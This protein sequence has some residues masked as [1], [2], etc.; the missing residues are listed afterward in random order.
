MLKH[1][2]NGVNI[3]QR[4]SQDGETALHIAARHN[5]PQVVRAFFESIPCHCDAVTKNKNNMT[6][7]H[8]A[9]N[10]NF[11]K[12]IMEVS[13]RLSRETLD[14]LDVLDDF[15]SSPLYIACSKGYLDVVKLLGEF[16]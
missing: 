2:T 5:R 11:P 9:A 16:F 3:N 7:L 6:A 15:G 14:L 13:K 12:V 8:I 10:L 1:S 4:H